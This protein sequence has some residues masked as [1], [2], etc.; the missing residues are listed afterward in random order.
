MEATLL[1]NGIKIENDDAIVSFENAQVQL[2]DLLVDFPGE[3]EHKGISL[4]VKEFGDLL[5]YIAHIDGW[6]VAYLSVDELPNEAQ[7]FFQDI[8]ILIV[9]ASKKG[10]ELTEKLSV[11]M[12][13][14]YGESIAE[15]V[16]FLN[17]EKQPVKKAKIKDSDLQGEDT[18]VV[19]LI[20][21]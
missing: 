3:Y 9:P 6:A 5:V 4:E 1:P 15:F 12:V 20:A 2:S 16:G 18:E 13:I 10:R 14:P 8:D 11:R 17:K 7:E 21:A 19:Y